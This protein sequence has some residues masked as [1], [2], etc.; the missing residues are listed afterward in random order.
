M[1]QWMTVFLITISAGYLLGQQP[2]STKNGRTKTKEFAG[3]VLTTIQKK[4]D[5]EINFNEKSENAFLEYEGKII[6]KIIVER[7]GFDRTV[8]DTTK[9]IRTFFAKAGNV[10]H[11]DT[12]PWVV[13]DNLF[14]REGKPLNP[15]RVADNERYIRDLDFILDSRIF[16]I[17][18]GLS[19]SVDLKVMTRDVFSI[20]GSFSANNPTD[21]DFSI[22][23][24]NLF[25]MGQ[26][27]IYSG[28]YESPRSPTYSQEIR[29]KK[30]NLFG[31]FVNG[32]LGFTQMD[33]AASLGNEH[34]NA[35][36]FRL[37]RPLF[38]P[39]T[40]FAGGLELS[41]NFSKNVY[42]RPDTLFGKYDYDIQD[43]WMGYSFGQSKLPNSQRENRNRKFIAIRTYQKKFNSLPDVQL[44][45]RDQ[46]LYMDR[47]SFLSQ[48]TFFKQDFYKTKYVLGFG[49]TEDIPYGYRVSFT[50]GWEKENGQERPYLSSDLYWNYV[51]EIGTI[52]TY[53]GKI[54]SYWGNDKLQDALVQFNFTRYSKIYPMGKANV[55]HLINVGYAEQYNQ[56]NK[57]GLDIRNGNGLSGFRPDSLTGT[58]RLTFQTEATVFTNWK[59]LGFHLAPLVRMDLAMINRYRA[60]FINEKN[61]F[62]G[63]SIALMARNENLIFN[64]VEARVFYFPNTVEGIP[65]LSVEFRTNLRI[66]YPTNLVNAPST[67]YDN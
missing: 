2:D 38:N 1:K 21:Y 35:W 4:P 6:R 12:K 9:K 10:L 49:R 55:R 48:L 27:L 40:R 43:F 42:A 7:V 30:V 50:G 46:L 18:D 29:Y 34:E 24:A 56:K 58:R 57:F 32:T 62:S 3:K 26:R 41:R 8:M 33:N 5:A 31:S 23:D 19:D 44:S 67:F 52:Y 63:F 16:V 64:T 59:V 11:N 45:P 61:F 39:F 36:Y 53:G 54:G 66:K 14:I 65:N 37:D 20:R 60:E 47:V 13:R 28:R 22:Q 51:T 17:W 25:G 15:Y